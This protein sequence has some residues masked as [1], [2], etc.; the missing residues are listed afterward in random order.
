[1][2]SFKPPKPKLSNFQQMA[3]TATVTPQGASPLTELFKGAHVITNRVLTADEVAKLPATAIKEPKLHNPSGVPESRLK[4]Y[5]DE[6]YVNKKIHDRMVVVETELEPFE[7][8]RKLLE[9]GVEPQLDAAGKQ[10][11]GDDKKGKTVPLTEARTKELTELRERNKDRINKLEEEKNALARARFRFSDDFGRVFRDVV[12]VWLRELIERG[13][14]RCQV[15]DKKIISVAMLH[16]DDARNMNCYPLVSNLPSWRNPPAPPVKKA[17][18]KEEEVAA[19]PEVNP[20]EDAN[21]RGTPSFV[22]YVTEMCSELTH[23]T[24]Y[25][26]KGVAKTSVHENKDEKTGDVRVNRIVEKGE[27][28]YANLRTSTQFKE[29][30]SALVFEFCALVSPLVQRHMTA[31]KI[32]TIQGQHLMSVIE[33]LMN[34][35]NPINEELVYTRT[36]ETDPVALKKY[37]E[38]LTAAKA[39]GPGSEDRVKALEATF[40]SLPKIDVLEI[41]KP[42]QFEGTRYP[43]F[44]RRLEVSKRLWPVKEVTAAAPAP[45]N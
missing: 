39:S 14:E 9:A 6:L 16:S 7:N 2:N 24:Q 21:T 41:T 32:K 20:D 13:A 1:M 22:Y 43:E 45:T 27:S 3:S 28:K 4:R 5:F 26:D 10:L 36:P 15:V 29:Y 18:A 31:L 12:V 40:A 8:A 42:M 30:L 35:G 11:V 25:D 34:V 23:P 17:A 38:D 33:M 19:A 37:K 44:L